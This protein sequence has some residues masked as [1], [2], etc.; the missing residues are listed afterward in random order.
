MIMP[1]RP[2]RLR[3]M[4]RTHPPCRTTSSSLASMDGV[5]QR[6]ARG[7]DDSSR[8]RSRVDE[9]IEDVNQHVDNDKAGGEDQDH[10]LHDRKVAVVD[11]GD[12]QPSQARAG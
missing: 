3:Q 6:Q 10:A 1:I 8:P 7:V 2:L 11:R 12:E 9:R 5:G 4:A